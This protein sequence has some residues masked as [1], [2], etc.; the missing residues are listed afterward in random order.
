MYCKLD[1]ENNRIIPA[2]VNDLERGIM[3][4]NLDIDMLIEDGYKLFVEAQPY[5][6]KRLHLLLYEETDTE[7]REV[8]QWQ[9]TKEQYEYRIYLE[10]KEIKTKEINEKIEELEKLSVNELLYGNSENVQV[11]KDV[12]D[13]LIETR[14][15]L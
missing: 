10:N 9:E 4:Y 8:I 11:Y 12:I 7:I 2:P 13:G 14:N 15:N 3:N 1:S 5:D 6:H